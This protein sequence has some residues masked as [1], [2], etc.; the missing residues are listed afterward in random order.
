MSE[1]RVGATHA[2]RAPSVESRG[3]RVGGPYMIAAAA[4]CLSASPAPVGGASLCEHP[5]FPVTPTIRRQYRTTYK[6]GMPSITHIESI[7]DITDAAF[8]VKLEFVERTVTRPWTC[9]VD[10]LISSEPGN[11]SAE[12]LMKSDKSSG[13]T[14]PPAD[15]WQPG[16]SW[17]RHYDMRGS[18]PVLPGS[19]VTGTLEIH[20]QVVGAER[21]T[22]EA[23]TF[24]TIKVSFLQAQ[25]F[26]MKHEGDEV[27]M[28]SVLKGA[29]WYAKGI[30]LVKTEIETAATTEL[31][32]FKQ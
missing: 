14:L 6:T 15:R 18:M 29:S 24:E 9:T 7:T 26:T 4:W 31:L 25:R 21:L 16:A 10:G 3:R 13:V 19:K 20:V 8:A 12:L 28:H 1:E 27:P 11:L 5:Y 22:V 17:Q 32:K 23:G 2:S 30:G